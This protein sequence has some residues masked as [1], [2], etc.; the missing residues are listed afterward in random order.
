MRRSFNRPVRM[1]RIVSRV[2]SWFS[3]SSVT[4]LLLLLY[5]LSREAQPREIRELAPYTCKGPFE[6]HI[7]ARFLLI[8]A[9]ERDVF[10]YVNQRVVESIVKVS[11]KAQVTIYSNELPLDWLKPLTFQGYNTLVQRYDITQ[12]VST[13]QLGGV[14]WRKMLEVKSPHFETHSSDLLRL[15]LLYKYGGIYLD[16]D[17]LLTKDLSSLPHNWLGLIDYL[18]LEDT[19]AWCLNGRWYIPNGLMSFQ[20]GS[21]F[22]RYVLT[23]LDAM[24]YTGTDRTEIGPKPFTIAYIKALKSGIEVPCLLPEHMLFPFQG[25]KI[26]DLMMRASTASDLRLL[27]AKETFSV[28]LFESTFKA[29]I[30]EP[31]SVIARSLREARVLKPG[32]NLCSCEIYK[33]SDSLSFCLPW[34]VVLARSQS[35]WGFPGARVCMNQ[36]GHEKGLHVKLE[37]RNGMLNR[38]GDEWVKSLSWSIEDIR[39]KLLLSTIRYVHTGNYCDDE[40]S[41]RVSQ[42]R[43]PEDVLNVKIFVSSPCWQTQ[44]ISGQ[45]FGNPSNPSPLWQSLP[46]E[47]PGKSLSELREQANWTSYLTSC[48]YLDR[49]VPLVSRVPLRV[50]V[51][52]TASGTYAGW[53]DGFLLSAE[54]FLLSD[55]EVHYYVFTDKDSLRSTQRLDGRLHVI[56]QQQHGWPLD[57]ELRHHYYLKLLSTFTADEYAYY[58]L[59]DADT[60]FVAPVGREILGDRVAVL[61][62]FSFGETDLAPW[63]HQ[64]GTASRVERGEGSC[65]Y[66]GGALGGNWQEMQWLFLNTTWS[67]EYDRVYGDAASF[68]DDEAHVNRYFIDHA[69]TASLS[70]DYIYPEPPVDRAWA[71]GGKNYKQA[72][73]PKIL[74]LGGRKHLG[75]HSVTSRQESSSTYLEVMRSS[76]AQDAERYTGGQDVTI[77]LQW[78]A[79]GNNN[80]DDLRMILEPFHAAVLNWHPGASVAVVDSASSSETEKTLKSISARLGITYVHHETFRE[81]ASNNAL[82]PLVDTEFLLLLG[83]GAMPTWQLSLP[84]LKSSVLLKERTY[85]SSSGLVTLCPKSEMAKSSSPVAACLERHGLEHHHRCQMCA[86]SSPGGTPVRV[87]HHEEMLVR[88]LRCVDEMLGNANGMPILELL[89]S[90]YNAV[91]ATRRWM[92]SES[93]PV[94]NTFQTWLCQPDNIVFMVPR[95]VFKQKTAPSSHEFSTLL[96]HTPDANRNNTAICWGKMPGPDIRRSFRNSGQSIEVSTKFRVNLLVHRASHQNFVNAACTGNFACLFAISKVDGST[97]PVSIDEARQLCGGLDAELSLCPVNNAH[98]IATCESQVGTEWYSEVSESTGRGLGW[99]ILRSR[100]Q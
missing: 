12:L 37:V 39:A 64:V 73:S 71:L 78:C 8:W 29:L 86:R 41:F 2:A 61:Q 23:S 5:F 59:Q 93:V 9:S 100:R 92:L 21:P 35:L 83:P 85:G 69:P 79:F 88:D 30:V 52:V 60:A 89:L 99:Q 25:P 11:P 94:N 43:Q 24:S 67:M 44:E 32:L 57:S 51:L 53:I 19:C 87:V 22:L 1:H 4:A 3:R 65:Y 13:V 26:G 70:L 80:H 96:L 17:A 33:V 45:R 48:V 55:C 63:E 74:N 38:Y 81:C 34:S 46:S 7:G 31:R 36:H 76:G 42:R 14:I 72:F 56:Y 20:P 54:R 49:N 90:H 68:H 98:T 91:F 28:H 97:V 16:T 27:R 18:N 47:V 75:A 50:A 10:S 82:L 95:P 40:L 6:T 15:L 62:A 77:I 84:F 66:A 58:L